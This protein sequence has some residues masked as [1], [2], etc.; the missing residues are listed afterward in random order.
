[1]PAMNIGKGCLAA[2]ILFCL[3]AAANGQG[4]SQTPPSNP[5]AKPGATIVINPTDQECKQGWSPS[6]RWTR[7]QFEAFCETLRKSK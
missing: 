7:E 3:S 1:M 2:A 6:M 5:Q 4:S